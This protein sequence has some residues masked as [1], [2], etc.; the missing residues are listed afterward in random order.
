LLTINN[1]SRSALHSQH[2]TIFYSIRYL[3]VFHFLVASGIS[4]TPFNSA[5]FMPPAKRYL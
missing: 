1:R 3:T 4:K 2:R 5:S